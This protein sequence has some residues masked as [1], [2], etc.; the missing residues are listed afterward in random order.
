MGRMG[1]VVH[2][3]KF[4]GPMALLL[5]LVRREEMDIFDI[6]INE[7]TKQYLDSIRAMRKLNLELAGDFIAMAATL[8]QIKSSML[9]PHYNENGEV[10]EPEQDPRKD[11]VRRLLEY[12]M[13]QEAGQSLYR[14]ELLGREVWGRGAREELPAGEEQIRI[15]EDNALYALIASYRTAVRNMKK[16]VHRVAESLQ[17]IADR[18]WEMR[19]KLVIG[20]TTKMSELLDAQ[21]DRKGQVL[22]T[23]LSLL[24]MAKI[25][26][27]GLFQSENFSDIHIETKREIDRDSISNV[28]SYE[29]HTSV[30]EDFDFI[31][32][33]APEEEEVTDS[34]DVLVAPATDEEI[35]RE[36]I[37]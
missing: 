37:L 3:D 1:V 22:I 29:T 34:P 5:H 31:M 32:D 24:E 36:D 10:V 6:N 28:E 35:E 27:V 20:Q 15:E 18:I 14:R 25:G 30:Q 19:L 4:S 8:I 21:T 33:T 26:L 16:A 23:F 11:L 2:I 17:S 7:I 9:L 12:Q 13:Y